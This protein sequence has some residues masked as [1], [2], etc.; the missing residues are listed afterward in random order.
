MSEAIGVLLTFT[1]Y[2]TRLHG[3]DNGSVS[4]SHR[5]RGSPVVPADIAWQRQAG[6]LMVEPPFTLRPRD[7][8]VVLDSVLEACASRNWHLFCV[9]VRTNHV[10]AILQT[11]VPVDR[12]LSYLKARATFA[13]KRYNVRQRFWTK[14]GST[15]Y[16]W[17][18]DSLAAALDYVL[19]QQG[20]P[21]ELWSCG[22]IG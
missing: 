18:R 6:R 16:L 14:H 3:A 7:R 19:N 5:N 20:A 11:D 22:S 12:T 10:H 1:T 4:R 8:T 21:M 2:G 13:L 9:H 17:N 15:R